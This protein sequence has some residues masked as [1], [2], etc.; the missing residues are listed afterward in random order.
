M[1]SSSD[2][3]IAVSASRADFADAR[4]AG[5]V[6]RVAAGQAARGGAAIE[7]LAPLFESL[8]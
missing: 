3:A 8:P 1:R 7:R 2:A 5:V 6:D 4:V